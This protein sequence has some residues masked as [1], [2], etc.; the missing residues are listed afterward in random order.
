[1]SKFDFSTTIKRVQ[2]NYKKDQRMANQ[3][4]DG[5][6]LEEISQDP[7]DYVVMDTWWK[8]KFGVM[9][10]KFGHMVQ[11]A[12]KSDSGKTSISLDAMK[13]AQDQGYGIIYVETES[14]TGPEDL[15]AA[16]IDPSGVICVNSS[17]TEEAFELG[18]KAWESFFCDYPKEKLLFVYDSFGN[19]TSARDSGISMTDKGAMVGGAAKTN[20][21]GLSIMRAKMI[22]DPVAVLLINRTYDNIGGKGKTNAGGD[23]VNFFSM[24]TVQTARKGWYEKTVNGQKVKAGAIVSWTVYKNHYAKA[25]KGPDGKTLL[26]P[27]FVEL[28]ITGDGIS[29][30][31]AGDKQVDADE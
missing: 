10:L 19:T 21:T 5:M 14:K 17:I 13:R 2:D 12:G 30:V 20:R 9:G 28:K 24:L 27:K 15:I 3:V 18:L 26:L 4:G 25:L 11:V 7:A 29:P 1:M 6:T 16:G 31:V 22:A 8:E 23:A